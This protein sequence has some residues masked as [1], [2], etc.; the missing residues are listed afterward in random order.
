MLD[1]LRGPPP[2]RCATVTGVPRPNY[3]L[4]YDRVSIGWKY[5]GTSR[6]RRTLMPVTSK[7]WTPETPI[8][9][10]MDTRGRDWQELM[11]PS[12]DG[13]WTSRPGYLLPDQLTGYE[14]RALGDLGVTVAN[15]VML[16]SI[17]RLSGTVGLVAFAI[18]CGCVGLP[19]LIAFIATAFM[20]PRG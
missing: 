10:V 8:T 19:L 11:R 18:I 1:D 12:T 2:E 14:R 6:T 15:G 20:K 9:I 13:E 5:G 3:R 17:D 4:N 16:Y 7:G